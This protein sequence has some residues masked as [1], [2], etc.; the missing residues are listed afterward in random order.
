MTKRPSSLLVTQIR[1]CCCPLLSTRIAWS[2]GGPI[3][4]VLEGSRIERGRKNRTN[5]RK[6]GVSAPAVVAQ[7]MRRRIL[8]TGGSEV[9]STTVAGAAGLAGVAAARGGA[10]LTPLTLGADN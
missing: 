7:T 6:N 5:I 2:A 3:R 1:Y 8:L 9:V 10:A 4:K